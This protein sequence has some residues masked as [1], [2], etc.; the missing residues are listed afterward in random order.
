MRRENKLVISKVRWNCLSNYFYFYDCENSNRLKCSAPVPVMKNS[1]E[2][3]ESYFT[4]K[5]FHCWYKSAPEFYLFKLL[6]IERWWRICNFVWS[7]ELLSKWKLRFILSVTYSSPQMK[8]HDTLA[9]FLIRFT[10]TLFLCDD[11]PVLVNKSFF[12]GCNQFKIIENV[13]CVAAKVRDNSWYNLMHF[14]NSDNSEIDG[15]TAEIPYSPSQKPSCLLWIPSHL[16]SN[17]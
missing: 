4:Q 8:L 3:G 1:T 2:A 17:F 9:S 16:Q 14:S 6:L 13:I 15:K 7:L 10:V 5:N 12:L 11:P